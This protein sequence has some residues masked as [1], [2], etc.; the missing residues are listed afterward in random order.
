MVAEIARLEREI[1]RL[2]RNVRRSGA[3]LD[4]MLLAA[5]Q[6]SLAAAERTLYVHS[7]TCEA[8]TEPPRRDAPTTPTPESPS[9]VR[10]RSPEPQDTVYLFI[11]KDR[12]HRHGAA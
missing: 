1:A 5:T 9:D 2:E 3:P 11:R 4:R 8:P 6:R 12:V 7:D 10:V